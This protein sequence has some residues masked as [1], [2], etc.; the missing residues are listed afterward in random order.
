MSISLIS[1][2]K[3]IE[4][5]EY[6]TSSICPRYRSKKVIKKKR[7]F[8]CKQCKLEAHRDS[9]GAVNM[10]FAQENLRYEDFPAEVMNR[11]VTRPQLFSL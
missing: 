3:V 11:A 8:K 1:L 9:V 5:K 7:L 6:D 10:R 4:V 2:I